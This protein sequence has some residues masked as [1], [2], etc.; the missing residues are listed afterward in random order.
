MRLLAYC[1]LPARKG[2]V[3]RTD[4]QVNIA[5]VSPRKCCK[6]CGVLDSLLAEASG[7]TPFPYNGSM[8]FLACPASCSNKSF[9]KKKARPRHPGIDL[10]V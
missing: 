2:E 8:I 7:S 9:I 3:S 1:E 4:C 10:L 6:P 5:T